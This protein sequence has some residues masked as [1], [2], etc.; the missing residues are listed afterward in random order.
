MNGCRVKTL[1]GY[2]GGK[3]EDIYFKDITMKKMNH[4]LVIDGLYTDNSKTVCGVCDGEKKK[5]LIPNHQIS[6][7]NKL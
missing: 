2:S 5:F 3:V 6:K 4:D 7:L 1:K